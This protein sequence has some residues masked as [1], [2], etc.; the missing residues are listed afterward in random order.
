M[1]KEGVYGIQS[2]K[3][4][5]PVV[6]GFPS[7]FTGFDFKAIVKDSVQF[8]DQ[9]AGTTDVEIED[10]D[11]PY[12]V[13]ESSAAQKGFTLQIYDLSAE[14]FAYLMGYTTSGNWNV[15][16]ATKNT[17]EKAVQ[18][19]TKT[20]GEFV[21]K[22]FQW[23]RMRID[24]TRAGTIGKSGFPN[25]T[26]T[27]RQLAHTDANGAA[28]SGARWAKTS[29]VASPCA[30]PTFSPASW[31]TG[32]TL[33]VTLTCATAGATIHYTTDGTTPT[34]ASP[35]YSSAISLS[36]TTTIKAIAVKDGYGQSEVASKSY[37][38][39]N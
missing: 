7:S 33:S 19:V 34:T 38:K 37:T 36:A 4:A 13:L 5:D 14:A 27:F 1:A 30:T 8:N 35:T 23:A 16:P 2:V 29:D 32:T 28:V 26:A 15:E 39:P 11:D 17:L 22:T 21:S 20:F 10:S 9:A 12:A 31:T 6:G 3:L 18:I 24:V 25:L